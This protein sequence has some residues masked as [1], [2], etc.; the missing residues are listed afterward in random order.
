MMDEKIKRRKKGQ[1]PIVFSGKTKR[2]ICLTCPQGCALET[3]GTQVAGARCEKGRSFVCQEW[4]EPLRVLTTTVR[5]KTE[6]GGRL[7]PI[8]TA[9]PVPLSRLS[10]MMKAL[11]ALQLSE[12]PPIG[13]TLIVPGLQAPLEVIVTGE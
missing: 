9:F 4:I 13:T 6:R 8:K 10:A 11:K 1:A 5:C 7:V 12:V 3:D 2:F